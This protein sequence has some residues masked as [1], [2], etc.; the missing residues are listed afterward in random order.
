MVK[1]PYYYVR[2]RWWKSINLEEVVE[3]L[4]K[5][6]NV[7]KILLPK[8]NSEV[9]LYKDEREELIVMADSLTAMLSSFRAILYQT[10]CKP[11]TK[12]DLELREKVLELYPRWQITP[13]PWSYKNEPE[14]NTVE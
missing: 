9:S 12:R 7:Q 14:F 6:F 8:N 3:A 11:F 1:Q 4:N 2:F 5:K 10:E 13:F